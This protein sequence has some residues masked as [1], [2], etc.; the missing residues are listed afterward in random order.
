MQYTMF[1]CDDVG[2]AAQRDGLVAASCQKACPNATEF[3][4]ALVMDRFGYTDIFLNAAGNPVIKTYSPDYH[5]Y[6]QTKTIAGNK[7]Y[8]SHKPGGTKAISTDAGGNLI[9]DPQAA[10]SARTTYRGPFL[11]GVQWAGYNDRFCGCYCVDA[12]DNH[13]KI[14]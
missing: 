10:D 6:Q 1:T 7:G 4:V 2:M 5:W 14:N 11:P 12:V 3:K 9:P 13:L 8:F